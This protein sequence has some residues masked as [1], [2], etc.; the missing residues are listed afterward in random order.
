MTELIQGGDGLD[1]TQL[2]CPSRKSWTRK[3]NPLR[4]QGP[5]HVRYIVTLFQENPDRSLRSS[6]RTDA[7]EA[8]MNQ[9]GTPRLREVR[10]YSWV[11]GGVLGHEKDPSLDFDRAV[12]FSSRAW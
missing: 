11:A 3:R 6:D 1:D 5:S 4:L 8:G 2:A 9:E 12:L 10:G 7:V